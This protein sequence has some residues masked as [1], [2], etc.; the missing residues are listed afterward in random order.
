MK[1]PSW[2]QDLVASYDRTAERYAERSFTSSTT[3]L[4]T[5][6]SSTTSLT[7]FVAGA[8]PVISDAVPATSPDT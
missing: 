8:K 2:N 6:N 3:S 5:A 7:P 1:N 4:S